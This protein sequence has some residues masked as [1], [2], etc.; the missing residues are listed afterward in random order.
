MY[1]PAHFKIEDRATLLAFMRRH[2]FA[3][4]VTHDGA[5]PHATHMPVLASEREGVFTLVTHMA[6]AN[7]QWRQFGD[8][9]EILVM[10]TGPH[11]YVSPVWYATE[12]AVPTWN[13]TAVHAYGRPC[14]VDDPA[15]LAAMLRELTEFF[16]SPRK[17]RWPGV[18]PE[19]FRDRL[20]AGIVGIE[21]EVT[22][23]EG[24]FKLSQNRSEADRVGV[25]TALSASGDQTDREVAELMNQI[26]P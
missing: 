8:G 5:L 18:M 1:S 4:I 24:K 6:R 10:F 16:E 9:Q 25:I 12:P 23:I 26:A 13:Y 3:S 17:D 14:I 11:A 22:R 2:S 15:R 20:M 19:E 7:P 21:I